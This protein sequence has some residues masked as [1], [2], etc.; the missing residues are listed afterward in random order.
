MVRYSTLFMS[1]QQ[2]R[3]R[4]RS[5]A[6]W[7]THF[8]MFLINGLNRDFLAS[9]NPAKPRHFQIVLLQKYKLFPNPLKSNENC[10]TLFISWWFFLQYSF[11]SLLGVLQ[12]FC[13]ELHVC[14]CSWLHINF[15]F[16]I[17]YRYHGF[18]GGF[19]FFKRNDELLLL[20]S[21]ESRTIYFD[22][23]LH[24][25]NLFLKQRKEP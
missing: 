2:K 18:L 14:L 16:F 1:N 12:C 19:Q 24:S 23:T 10:L 25:L 4:R 6:V 3:R 9:Q 5:A 15:F 20:R 8:D 21:P 11:L 13:M 17:A 22:V 7:E